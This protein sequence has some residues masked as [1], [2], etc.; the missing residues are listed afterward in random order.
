VVIL[1]ED[2]QTFAHTHGE[3]VGAPTIHGGAGGHDDSPAHAP[4]GAFGPEIAFHHTFPA[5]GDYKVWGQFRDHH[6]QILTADF[7]VRAS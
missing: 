7:V 4:T 3:Q 1:S 2:A 6:G 5:P